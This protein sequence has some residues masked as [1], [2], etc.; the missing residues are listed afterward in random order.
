MNVFELR[1]RVIDDYKQFSQ[2]FL[3]IRANDLSLFLEQRVSSEASRWPEPRLA[4]NP[5]FTTSGTVQELATRGLLHPR[6]AD[7][8]RKRGASL[9]LY[10]HQVEAIEAA[11]RGASYVLTT[12]T[13]SGK[14]LAYLIPA[15]D[16][17][18]R[19]ASAGVKA[20]VVYPMNALVNSQHEE[21]RQYHEELRRHLNDPNAEPLAT[22]RS[23]TGQ[24]SKSER[25]EILHQP[26]DI[27]LTNYVML[28]LLLTRPRE[29]NQLVDAMRGSLRFVVLDELHTYRGRQGAD[30]ALLVRRLRQVCE[31]PDLQC[32]GTSAT[33]ATDGTLDERRSAV[34]RAATQVFGCHIPPADVITETLKPATRQLA[35]S[36][37]AALSNRVESPA[38]PATYEAF[39]DDPLAVWVED[40][41]GASECPPGSGRFERRRPA[42]IAE[43]AVD[44]SALTGERADRCTLAIAHTLLAGTRL[45]RPDPQRGPVFAFRLHQLLSKGDTIYVSLERPGKRW[46]TLRYQPSVPHEP[47]KPLYP[48]VFCRECGQEYLA[49]RRLERSSGSQLK[50]QHDD[51]GQ[52]GEPGYLYISDEAPWPSDHDR[53]IERLPDSWQLAGDVDPVRQASMPVAVDVL[54]DGTFTTG[55]GLRAAFVPAPF[56]FCLS[57]GT[58]YESARGS[59][60][61]RLADLGTEGRSS[62]TTVLSISLVRALRDA[63]RGGELGGT[64]GKL[65]A[66]TDN[67]QDA[68]LQAGHFND[69]VRVAVLRGALYRAVAAAPDGLNP[70]ELERRVFG[71]LALPPEAYVRPSDLAPDGHP[72]ARLEEAERALCAVIG[73]RLYADLE[74]GWRVAMPN[75]EQTGLLIID[76]PWLA[77]TVRRQDWWDATHPVLRNASPERRERACRVLLDELRRALA[78]ET[79]YLTGLRF[80]EIRNKSEQWLREPWIL[81]DQDEAGERRTV[82]PRSR[83][84]D[85]DRRYDVAMSG[86]SRFGGWLRRRAFPEQDTLKVDV[87]NRMIADLLRV[88][89]RGEL[90]V[91]EPAPGGRG[92]PGYRVRAD[93]LRWRAG[94]G[95]R[96]APEPTRQSDADAG[97]L[98]VNP[99]FRELYQTVACQLGELSAREHTAQVDPDDRRDREERFRKAELPIL[100][101][102]PTMEL[103]VDIAD[104]N[105]VVLRNVPPT[106]ANYAQRSGRA[107]RSGQPALV[108]TYCTSNSGHDQY[109]FRNPTRLISGAVVPPRLDLANEDLVRA[110]VHAVWLAETRVPLGQALSEVLDMDADIGHLPTLELRPDVRRRLDDDGARKRAAEHARRMLAADENDLS[111]AA[112][113]DGQWVERVLT[114]TLEAFDAACNRWRELYWAALRELDAHNRAARQIRARQGKRRHD[115]ARRR[116]AERQLQ[117]LRVETDDPTQSDFYVYRYLA[118]EGFLP[119]YSFPRLPLTAFLPRG[120][121]NMKEGRYLLR[122]RFIAL[123]EFGP[124]ALIYHEGSHYDVVGVQLPMRGGRADDSPLE[125]AKRCSG[126]GYLHDQASQDRDRCEHCAAELP[127][128]IGTL[129]P[130]QTV[131]TVPRHRI[132]SDEEERARRGFEVLVSYRFGPAGARRGQAQ[133]SDVEVA[134]AYGDSTTIHLANL[135]RRNR[136]DA[137]GMGFLLDLESGRWLTGTEA[138][139][140]DR[141]VAR[142]VV[143]YV[144]DRRNALILAFR[145]A[146]GS[147]A[148]LTMQHALL[149]AIAIAFELE[150]SELAVEPLPNRRAPGQILLYEASEGGAG[151]L[152]RLVD[153]PDQF[154]RVART[155]LGLLHFLPDDT[156]RSSSDAAA[157]EADACGRACYEC[158]LSY[159]NQPDHE[160]LDR[161]LVRDLLHALTAT[162][163]QQEPSPSRVGEFPRPPTAT[164]DPMRR[165]FLRVAE[166]YG[167]RQPTATGV[168]VPGTTVTPD[169]RYEAEGL[170]VA[171]LLSR[172]QGERRDEAAALE[173]AG[174]TVIPFWFE[175]R[176]Q[177]PQRLREHAFAFGPGNGEQGR[178]R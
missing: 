98:R 148:M 82:W 34:A 173:D 78:I 40:R 178:V 136:Q 115:D 130:L 165:E 140:P 153:E 154:A 80:D 126:C 88:L 5:T 83:R 143:P 86:L 91:C 111:Q 73:R 69:F 112:W 58:A 134:L 160:R 106:P 107:G 11:R 155:A 17:A 53:Q 71:A 142:G 84:P 100:Y 102:S 166:R 56:L 177:W 51:E 175:D 85:D 42:T 46:R 27:L 95:K 118:A 20:L 89:H 93:A 12:G 77:D 28:D 164:E 55:R 120:R 145:P 172:R 174:W 159:T 25:A 36:D 6:C 61:G 1:D 152:R 149:R 176:D 114:D 49:V 147:E 138:D 63:V 151:V 116:Q 14:S 163:M 137:A 67:R 22:F 41:F 79:R 64:A 10:R 92:V 117:L 122:P 23:Y 168:L 101:C 125:T 52:T 90:L 103:G 144:E 7:F 62:A 131:Q 76:Y 170:Q 44:L 128:S 105:A 16:E 54:P 3:D 127:A 38:A 24:E 70:D 26:P 81:D 169:F 133:T 119:G 39:V 135:G 9:T 33:M 8:F 60:Y 45:H 129:L 21:L 108:V 43:A 59:E 87:A 30:V 109:H 113:F 94:D 75:L 141:R 15:V 162:R 19:N 158:L 171:V 99:Y 139:R 29:R 37:L 48:L 35:A 146:P 157:G 65:L 4:L 66:F 124:R 18:L 104:L 72:P 97:G 68:A 156:Q 50:P 96:R 110:H 132:T 123:G 150:D 74:R 31:R 47:R 167:H 161:H 121:S 57:C 32:I 13:G 2:S